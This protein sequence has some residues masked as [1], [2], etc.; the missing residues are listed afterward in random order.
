MV[1]FKLFF[2]PKAFIVKNGKVL[3]LR[4]SATHPT[5]THAGEYSL[6]GGRIEPNEPWEKGFA[7]EV[8]EEIGATF[9]ILK[10]LWVSESFNEVQKEKWHIVRCF[11]LCKMEDQPIKLSGEH[12]Q[13]KW[14]DPVNYKNENLIPNEYGV[15][16]AYLELLNK[17]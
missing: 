5:N 3:V 7:R 17:N 12:D 13:F 9:K 2:A 10:P 16:E 14:I 4:E 6:I 8:N 11:F 1:K 15:F